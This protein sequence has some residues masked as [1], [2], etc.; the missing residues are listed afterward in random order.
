MKKTLSK[1]F[2]SLFVSAVSVISLFTIIVSANPLGVPFEHQQ[3][4]NWCWAATSVSVASFYGRTTI[5]PPWGYLTQIN[6]TNHVRAALNQQYGTPADVVRN[7]TDISTDFYN[8]YSIG[9]A[10]H[11]GSISDN[12]IIHEINTARK[13]IFVRIL[14]GNGGGHFIL[15]DGEGSSAYS[16]RVMDPSNNTHYWYANSNVRNNYGGINYNSTGGSWSHT[17]RFS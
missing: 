14:W 7:M 12:N 2:L 16:L 10:Y 5:V 17:M 13:P 3:Q 6:Q 4:S 11:I 9:A 8:L 15:I 1:K